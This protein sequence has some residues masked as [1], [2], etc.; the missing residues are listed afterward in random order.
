[1]NNWT[2]LSN[3]GRVFCYL[4]KHPRC[5]IA[6]LA[7]DV[8]LSIA[9]VNRILNEL[10]DGGYIIRRRVGRCNEY[11]IHP[12]LPMR[13]HLEWDFKVADILLALNGVEP[14]RR[15]ELS[16]NANGVA[17]RELNLN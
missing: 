11:T 15:V 14:K 2:F 1:M 7:G 10:E 8:G 5:T 3:H 9:G 4:A 16:H 13:H 12:E 6:G 17:G